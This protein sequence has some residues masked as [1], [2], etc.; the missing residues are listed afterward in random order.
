MNTEKI[1]T[2]AA[3]SKLT[4]CPRSTIQ[5]AIGRGEIDTGRLAGGAVVVSVADVQ[6]WMAD[7]DRRTGPKAA[8][9]S[10]EG[11]QTADIVPGPQ[12]SRTGAL[13]PFAGGY[14]AASGEFR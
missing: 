11:P 4:G 9:E 12:E 2:V 8:T 6:L 10:P 14:D 3:V 1:D 5:S 7:P 13:M